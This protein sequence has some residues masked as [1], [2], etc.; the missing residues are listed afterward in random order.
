M[1]EIAITI[2][3]RRYPIS[4]DDGQEEHAARLAA[5]VDKR[6]RE[7]SNAVGRVSEAKLLVMTSLV[8]ADE[9][10][11]ARDELDR[12]QSQAKIAEWKARSDAEAALAERYAPL[13]DA[14]AERIESIA[15]R[16]EKD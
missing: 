15:G 3:G 2:G 8:I 6:A 16:M 9:L 13:I 7:L 10:T 14:L 1:G 5:Y 12:L 11:D 4:C